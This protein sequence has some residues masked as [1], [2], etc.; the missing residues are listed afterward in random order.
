MNFIDEARS[1][2]GT[3]Y[4]KGA[5]TKQVGCDCLGF[6]LGVYSSEQEFKSLRGT[7]VTK[8]S[9]G[10]SKLIDTDLDDKILSCG[11]PRRVKNLPR[12]DNTGHKN[13]K[14]PPIKNERFFSYNR[15]QTPVKSDVREYA[16]EGLRTL[17]ND[18]E[19]KNIK[20]F[21]KRDFHGFNVPWYNVP[22]EQK[23]LLFSLLNNIEEVEKVDDFAIGIFEFSST[24][25]HVGIL[26]N[27]K[28][29]LTLIHAHEAVGKV[30]EHRLYGEML[31]KLKHIY[32]FIEV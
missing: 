3:K 4:K 27:A 14:N 6:V 5:H 7:V 26:V 12:S 15:R 23:N 19:E 31:S 24:D 16:H 32:K 21:K 2:I 11:L 17:D 25:E 20:F 13:R 28:D 18:L 29:R 9:T 8:Q 22:K 30:V 10:R 1:W